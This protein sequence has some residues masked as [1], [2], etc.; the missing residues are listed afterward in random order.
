MFT[1]KRTLVGHDQVCGL[2]EKLPPL[3]DSR[4][5]AQVER[6]ASMD[7]PL[8]E[9]SIQRTDISVL[10]HQ[11]LQSTKI[12]TQLLRRNRG[13]LPALVVLGHVWDLRGCAKAL[14]AKVPDE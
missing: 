14:F 8:P 10:V 5:G 7:T 12:S 1:G 3:C 13:V 2:A 4:R 6:E 9:V 11:L